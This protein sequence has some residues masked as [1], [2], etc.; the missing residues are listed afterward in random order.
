MT[1]LD[2]F[3]FFRTKNTPKKTEE[4]PF[5]NRERVG[6]STSDILAACQKYDP[7]FTPQKR[8]ELKKNPYI[9]AAL[10]NTREELVAKWYGAGEPFA[11]EH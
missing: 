2:I 10:R 7:T 11:L 3:P 4:Q 8:D 6:L 5:P 1:I 9:Y